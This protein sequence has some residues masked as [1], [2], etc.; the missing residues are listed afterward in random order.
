MSAPD[1]DEILRRLSLAIAFWQPLHAEQDVDYAIVN[2]LQKIAVPEGYNAIY[3]GTGH[4]IINTAA[5]HIAGEMPQIEV[6]VA[7]LSI[8]SQERSERL[9]K[10][11]QAA[12][13]RIN[14]RRAE[15]VQRTI[16]LNGLWSG[17]FVSR[18]P[19]FQADAWGRIPTRDGY[20][21]QASYE[22]AQDEY[23]A[24]KKINW[25]I[26]RRAVDPRFVFPD[27]GTMGKKWVF[28]RQLRPVSDIRAQ[29]PDWDGRSPGANKSDPPIGDTIL[30]YWIEYWDE[31][32]RAYMVGGAG[33]LGGG[34][35]SGV[36]LDEV[37]EHPYGKPP[38]QI[39]SSGYGIDT[40]LPW[41][42][43]RS[44]LYPAR[45]LLNQEIA[46]LN[47]LDAIMRRTAWPII[48]EASGVNL[49]EISPGKVYDIPA[50]MWGKVQAFS[51]Y[52]P[53]V[54][55]GLMTELEFLQD[56]IEAATFPNV[57]GGMRAKGIASGYGQNSLV[58]E[59]KVKF[60]A[61]AANLESLEEEFNADLCRCVK[62]AI[63]EDLPIW[64]KTKWGKLDTVLTPEDCDGAVHVEVTINPKLPTDRANEVAIVQVKLALGLIDKET[65][66]REVGYPEALEMLE[67][68][69][70]DRA[71]D[72]PEI[73][74]VLNLA[75]LMENGYMQY[76]LDAAKKIGMD[77]G[78]LLSVLGLG[79][80]QQQL[81]GRTPPGQ[82]GN[83]AAQIAPPGM[84]MLGQPNKEQPGAPITTGSVGRPAISAATPGTQ[85]NIRDQ[86]VP[87]LPIT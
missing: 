12:Q 2:N 26:Y 61:A 64:G 55:Q 7:G 47:Q 20:K 29:W 8:K 36:L 27:P 53:V 10:A 59:A 84:S 58:A 15:N 23:R 32:Y 37:R 1:L 71:M 18:G 68:I 79:S 30:V 5:D 13:Y 25:P 21:D 73:Q 81:P 67:K 72:S 70:H 22:T 17:M 4:R 45:S 24:T 57:V 39:R 40:G 69:Y 34:T 83:I 62:D 82:P 51:G 87:G 65:A 86:S 75:S 19:L 60:G 77:P 6:P 49:K 38:F 50:E 33:E 74:R 76:V 43:F 31:H 42:R 44:I 80:P 46:A 9:E 28:V 85:S 54:V 66:I 41:E 35:G 78:Q 52:D 48:L 11:L 63:Q 56:R 3:T 14:A 16:V